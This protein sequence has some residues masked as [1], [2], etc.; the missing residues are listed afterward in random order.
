MKNAV[1]YQSKLKKY[2]YYPDCY[3]YDYAYFKTLTKDQIKKQ[4]KSTVKQKDKKEDLKHARLL[5]SYVCNID[6]KL[7]LRD[8]TRLYR[9]DDGYLQSSSISIQ[10]EY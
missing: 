2:T 6:E 3:N 5:V 7:W 8:G 4:L 1:T 10:L 9:H